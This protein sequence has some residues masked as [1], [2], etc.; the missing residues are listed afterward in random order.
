MRTLAKAALAAALLAQAACS[1][2]IDPNS[3]DAPKENKK[4]APRGACVS[5][6]SHKL[7]GGDVSGGAGNTASASHRAKHGQVTASSFP[8]ASPPVI[9]SAQHKIVRGDVS[10]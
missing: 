3:V 2:T 9:Q 6:A 10:P 5:S 1:L 8:A 7:C 4:V